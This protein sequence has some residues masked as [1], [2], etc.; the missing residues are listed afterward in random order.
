MSNFSWWMRGDLDGIIHG[1]R[2]TDH[3]IINPMGKRWPL[4]DAGSARGQR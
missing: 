4:K 2:V 3:A 1:Y